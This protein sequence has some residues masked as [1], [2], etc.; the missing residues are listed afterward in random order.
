[1]WKRSWCPFELIIII[2][3]FAIILQAIL[4]FGTNNKSYLI[5]GQ[6]TLN[7][8][9][10]AFLIFAIQRIKG[11]SK[12]DNH[13]LQNFLIRKLKI[14]DIWI[15]LSLF[16]LSK[17]AYYFLMKIEIIHVFGIQGITQIS[18]LTSIQT[19]IFTTLLILFIPIVAL[20]EELYFRCYLFELQYLRFKNYTWII[21][22][23]SWSIYHLFTPTN[24]L[25]L[26]PACLMYSYIYQR[27]R[28]IWIT[29][30]AHLLMNITAI[31]PVIQSLIT[32]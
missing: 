14:R 32:R 31:S 9:Y 25:A 4:F 30:I 26:L 1:M 12:I 28:N 6:A 17:L 5:I 23:F 20:T 15:A 2:C 13:T 27:Y 16:A 3:A 19:W 21:N 10:F 22:G 29:I 7:I 11:K 18:H 24:F 8:A